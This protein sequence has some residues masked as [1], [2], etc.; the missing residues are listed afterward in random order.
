[1]FLTSMTEEYTSV[2]HPV[3]VASDRVTAGFSAKRIDALVGA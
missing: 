1:M 2:T 3:I